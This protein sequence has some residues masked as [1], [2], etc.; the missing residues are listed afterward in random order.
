MNTII[1]TQILS[2]CFKGFGYD[3]HDHNLA[4]SSI[5]ANEFLLAQPREANYPDYYIIHPAR[6][7]HLLQLEGNSSRISDHFGNP[8]WAKMSGQRTDKVI[9][10]FG[11]QFSPYREFGN[12]AISVIIN[13]KELDL[14]KISISHLPKQKQKYLK[15]RLKYIIDGNY[16]CYSLNKSI[17]E[18]ALY[19]FS[20]FIFE[21][22]CKEN[23]RNT[24]NDLLILAT[25]I[26]HGKQFLTHD[27]LLN[28]FASEYYNAP[29]HKERNEIL[30]DFSIQQTL[31]R[32]KN[33]ESKGY[34][35]RGW[36]YS[37]SNNRI[38]QGI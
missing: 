4:I 2:Y 32:K 14:Y 15:K 12:E 9:I 17:I 18:Q 19:L 21:H 1:D 35:N 10:D 11:N 16:Y 28:R 8:K 23:I 6:Y 29:I 37:F 5:T 24:I 38:T 34:I 31:E 27:N 33:E 30:I 13:D 25:A 3:I 26:N 20:Q 36:S 22:N 7:P